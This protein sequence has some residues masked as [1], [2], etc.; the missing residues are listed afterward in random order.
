MNKSSNIKLV[1]SF[2]ILNKE[3]FELSRNF[4]FNN[5]INKL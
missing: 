3:R 1:E 4:Y 2:V 5:K